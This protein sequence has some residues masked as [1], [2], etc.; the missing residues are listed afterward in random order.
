MAEVIERTD[1]TTCPCIQDGTWDPKVM[2]VQIVERL[3]EFAKE[4][5]TCRAFN[6]VSCITAAAMF[7]DGLPANQSDD[8]IAAA[9][10][11]FIKTITEDSGFRIKVERLELGLITDD[12]HPEGA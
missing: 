3:T 1:F 10:D 12:K 5:G 11:V 9:L 7:C 8:I 6:F 2:A 4:N